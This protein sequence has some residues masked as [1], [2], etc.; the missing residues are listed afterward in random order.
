MYISLSAFKR[1]FDRKKR[2]RYSRERADLSLSLPPH[3]LPLSI[4]YGTEFSP[5]LARHREPPYGKL[6]KPP[7]RRGAWRAS[8]DKQKNLINHQKPA[9]VTRRLG[10]TAPVA[11]TTG[12]PVVFFAGFTTS[13]RIR[14]GGHE[15]QRT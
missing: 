10:T 2:R 8:V 11:V 4:K 15:G 3:K 6:A 7:F 12:A 1:V 14:K 9:S 13:A 5:A